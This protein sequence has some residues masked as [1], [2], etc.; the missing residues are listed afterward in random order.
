VTA[1]TALSALDLIERDVRRDSR[2]IDSK[3]W[4]DS[5]GTQVITFEVDSEADL[6]TAVGH[7]AARYVEYTDPLMVLITEWTTYRGVRVEAQATTELTWQHIERDEVRGM[8]TI[9]ALREL[10]WDS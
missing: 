1:T 6:T 5:T 10:G 4:V 9:A 2:V 7:S 8:P 3:R